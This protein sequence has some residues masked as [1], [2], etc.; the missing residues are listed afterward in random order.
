MWNSVPHSKPATRVRRGKISTCQCQSNSSVVK[1]VP[2][3]L[4]TLVFKAV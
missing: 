3:R 2:R 4:M 1:Y